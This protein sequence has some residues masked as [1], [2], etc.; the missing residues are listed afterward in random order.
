MSLVSVLLVGAGLVDVA[1]FGIDGGEHAARDSAPGDAP[2]PVAAVG[3]LG[4]FDILPGNQS[5][6]D[7]RV[8]GLL[9]ELLLGRCPS[10][11]SASVTRASTSP[12]RAWASF[13]AIR[14]LPGPV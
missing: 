9:A 1:G 8:R 5:Q 12:A 10:S 2:A 14:G 13:Q 3:V 4:R 11:R 6:D 7:H